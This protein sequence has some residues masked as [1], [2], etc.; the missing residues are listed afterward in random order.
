VAEA[1]L[2]FA[3]TRVR[4][5]AGVTGGDLDGQIT[6]Q[7]RAAGLDDASIGRITSMMRE[8]GGG[9]GAD[10][11]QALLSVDG[12]TVVIVGPGR[13]IRGRSR[14][15][16]RALRAAEVDRFPTFVYH[17]SKGALEAE[18]ALPGAVE[19]GDAGAEDARRIG[20]LWCAVCLSNVEE[21]SVVRMLPCMHAF[22]RECIDG[23]FARANTCPV[24]KVSM[25][26]SMFAEAGG[27][28]PGGPP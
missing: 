17:R 5:S 8:G 19:V 10:G 4:A 26:D 27:D 12:D 22:D 21:G 6:G 7:L 24:C 23:W 16:P 2:A 14:P 15:N 25:R 28:E 11:Y 1:H 20:G 3:L 9:E 18:A 13:R